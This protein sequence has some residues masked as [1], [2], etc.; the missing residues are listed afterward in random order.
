MAVQLQST[1]MSAPSNIESSNTSSVFRKILVATAFGMLI[2]GGLSLYG[3]VDAVS[4]ELRNFDYR[5]L[6]LALGLSLGNFLIRACRWQYYLRYVHVPVPW[7]ESFLV[8]FAGMVMTVTPGKAGE[9]FKSFLLKWTRDAPLAKTSA[10]VIA[11]RVTDLVALLILSAWGILLFP[12]GAL[13]AVGL[14]CIAFGLILVVA[15]RGAALMCLNLLARLPYLREKK[16]R[17]LEAYESLVA[18]LRPFPLLIG[19]VLAVVAWSLQVVALV[20][21]VFG[22]AQVTISLQGAAFAYCSPLLAGVIAFLPGGIGITE[23]G[24]ASALA[25]TGAWAT[26]GAVVTVTILGRL[27]TLWF[28]VGLGGLALA[29]HRQ[30]TGWALK[31]DASA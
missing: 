21:L 29:V 23:V 1:L 17:L 22:A 3:D 24:M 27:A 4:R 13:F 14:L 16:D 25:Q 20:A 30:I 2:F 31:R 28:A 8:F 10:I 18:V 19:V 12:A 11:E 5:Y 7:V 6:W 9:V 15:W 26:P